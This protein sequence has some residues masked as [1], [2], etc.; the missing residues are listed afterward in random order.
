MIYHVWDVAGYY[1][2]AV[3]A[4]TPEGAI[5]LARMSHGIKAAMVQDEQQFLELHSI[6]NNNMLIHALNRQ[7]LRYA[8]IKSAEQRTW[9][10]R[11][12]V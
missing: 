9:R 4:E 10:D 2:T 11:A 8:D 1:R 5:V 6:K 12:F 7:Q 3:T